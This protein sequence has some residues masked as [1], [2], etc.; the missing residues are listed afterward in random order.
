MVRIKSYTPPWLSKPA[1]GHDVFAPADL[2]STKGSAT[3]SKNRSP[4]GPRRT[5]A[6]RGTEVFVAV[7]KEIRWADLVY[8]KERWQ[9][10]VDRSPESG[11][12]KR[13]SSLAPGEE[14]TSQS[15]LSD[16]AEGFRVSLGPI[17]DLRFSADYRFKY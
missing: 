5:I 2:E 3:S 9:D 14:E 7:G 12:F 1:I 15:S 8:L 16:D 17:D 4:P 13:E 6:R 10:G 11:R